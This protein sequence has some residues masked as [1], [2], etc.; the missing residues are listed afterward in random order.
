MILFWFYFSG[1]SDRIIRKECIFTGDWSQSTWSGL[2]VLLLRVNVAYVV[3]TEITRSNCASEQISLT[4]PIHIQNI[5]TFLKLPANSEAHDQIV[6]MWSLIWS[7]FC[8]I[9]ISMVVRRKM[10]VSRGQLC[11]FK[12]KAKLVENASEMKHLDKPLLKMQ[13]WSKLELRNLES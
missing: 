6:R 2:P 3:R 8:T 4:F 10:V 9:F 1:L 12:V 11:Y 5:S 13:I 7:D